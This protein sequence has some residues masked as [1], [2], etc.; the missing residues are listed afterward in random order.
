VRQA[1]RKLHLGIDADS[2]ARAGDPGHGTP[3]PGGTVCLSAADRGGM[4]VSFI[5]SN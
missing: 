4:M 2:G 3:G 5:Q 1:W